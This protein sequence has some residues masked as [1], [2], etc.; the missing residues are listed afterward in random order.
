M[1][2]ALADSALVS[3]SS[4]D[5]LGL[6]HHPA[7]VEACRKAALRSGVGS[8]AARSL[9][10][11]LDVHLELENAIAQFKGTESAVV[12]G[13]GYHANVAVMSALFDRGDAIGSD[14]LNHA[15][16]IDG[17]RV[18]G[19]SPR[20][21]RH[22]VPS[23][24]I[25]L[26]RLD[27]LRGVVTDGVFS[28]DGDVAPL[29]EVI[30]VAET[31]NALVIVDDAHGTGVVGATGR[32]TAEHFGLERGNHVTVGTLSKAIGCSG[33]FIAGPA[34]VVDQVRT[35]G[36]PYVFSTS[37]PPPVAAAAVAAFDV[38]MS[39]PH[40]LRR[41]HDNVAQF[42]RHL[43]DIGFALESTPS[44]ITP[45]LLRDAG[46][47]H[48]V[49]AMLRSRGY[50]IPAVTYPVVP[51]HGARLRAIVTAEHRDDEIESAVACLRDCLT[52]VGWSE[53]EQ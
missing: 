3:F 6:S 45:V 21:Y 30:R 19:V 27:G 29:P 51:R 15:S 37:L 39:E 11:T 4:N 41:L 22:L 31:E 32:G 16:I 10:G 40:R 46:L 35:R 33:G 26:D 47:A 14:A 43:S 25:C 28:M 5:Y 1:S 17:C 49:S 7:V 53:R 20:I 36:R 44:A 48:Q 38:V 23:E 13:S 8:G 50:I 12:L 18:A 34:S 2:T 52:A 24:L 9:G 42:R